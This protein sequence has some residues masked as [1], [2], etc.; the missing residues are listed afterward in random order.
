MNFKFLKNPLRLNQ[1][2]W[3]LKKINWICNLNLR[4]VRLDWIRSKYIHHIEL[5]QSRKHIRL[6][7]FSGDKENQRTYVKCNAKNIR[8]NDIRKNKW[9]KK[10]MEKWKMKKEKWKKK[11]KRK[12]Q[13]KFETKN[14]KMRNLPIFPMLLANNEKIRKWS[15]NVVI[16]SLTCVKFHVHS[17]RTNR[18][19]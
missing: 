11:A 4:K 7:L 13:R 10:K 2:I 3:M 6:N 16:R 8:W 1:S 5:P 18:Q 15:E 9:K 17:A 12:K 19:V 14:M